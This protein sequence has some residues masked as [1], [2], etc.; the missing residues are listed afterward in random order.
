MGLFDSFFGK[1]KDNLITH[2]NHLSM[3][4]MS[5]I[6][7]SLQDKMAPAD[8]NNVFNQACRLVPKGK[9]AEAMAMF[10]QVKANTD[11]TE[12]KGTCDN[13]IGVCHFFLEDYEKA[14]GSYVSSIENGFEKA[15]ADDNIWEAC[16]KLMKKE[17]DK[18]KWA[19]HYIKLLPQ[20]N[21]L[22]QAQK[23]I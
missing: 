3:D 20:G 17:N 9:Y 23:L 12:Q 16:E 21:Y 6:Q 7:D 19:N 18:A 15:M 11:S 10:E 5:R 1:K 22:K 2:T 4:E 13:Q 8:Y 14:I